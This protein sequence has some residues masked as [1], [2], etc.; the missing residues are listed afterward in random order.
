MVMALWGSLFPMVK[1][2]YSAFGIS[3]GDI[4]QIMMFAGVRFTVCGLI[5]CLIS[6]F[7]KEQKKFNR[8][9]TGKSL[10]PVLLAGLFSVTIHYTCTYICLTLTDSS[11]T[12]ILKQLGSLIYICFGFLFFK[13]EKFSAAKIV[14]AV[15]GFIGIV[16]INITGNGF[17]FSIAD[18]LIL[19]AS[20][21]TVAG[22]LSS[23]AAMKYVS[24]LQVTGYSQ[25]FGGG[26]LLLISLCMGGKMLS[27]SSA[28]LPVFLYICI[29]SII[30]YCLW[31]TI[32][33][34]TELSK[35]FLIKFSEPLFACLFG[36]IILKEDIFKWQYPVA[37]LLISF[38]IVL[39]NT[40]K[41]HHNSKP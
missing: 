36:M 10:P 39:G 15:I 9:N 34:K 13:D 17:S 2:G 26:V 5:I 18:M 30:S 37:F 8:E 11:K 25:L 29:A 12:A 38:G 24:P 14:G 35:M 21:C 27:I 31:N 16:V 4:P 20:V 33:R 3:S 7:S 23:K 22:S 6:C 32:I 19:T 40:D 28:S 1:L 41:I